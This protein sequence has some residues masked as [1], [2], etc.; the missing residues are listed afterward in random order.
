MGGVSAVSLRKLGHRFDLATGIRHAADAL[1]WVR[2]VEPSI[3][4]P[5]RIVST[6]CQFLARSPG[7]RH[8][9]QRARRLTSLD[10]RH[11]P[12]VR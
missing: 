2:E 8:H 10:E 6:F 3:V 7:N 12:P 4:G 1:V 9:Q 11:L 5:G